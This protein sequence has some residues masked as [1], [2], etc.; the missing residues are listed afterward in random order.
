MC[1][2]RSCDKKTRKIYI[3]ANLCLI[4]SLLPT[5]LHPNWQAHHPAYE[6]LRISLLGITIV[7]LLWVARR[8]RGACRSTGTG[9]IN[10]SE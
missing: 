9:S 1:D 6:A 10:M 7:L 5:V 4:A 2:V 8:R 3:A